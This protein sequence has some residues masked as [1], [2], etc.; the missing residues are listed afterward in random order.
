MVNMIN[1]YVISSM[2]ICLL[3]FISRWFF[4]PVNLMSL[5]FY[6]PASVVFVKFVLK[7]VDLLN[8]LIEKWQW[9]L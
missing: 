1:I 6:L 8:T 4:V 7:D 2:F 5:Y 9:Q 3:C